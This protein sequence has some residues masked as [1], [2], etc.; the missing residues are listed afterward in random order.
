MSRSSEVTHPRSVEREISIDAPVDVVW[1]ALTDA[2]ELM[3]WFPLNATVTP[4]VG[5]SIMTR[6]DEAH[7]NDDGRIEIWEPEHHLRTVG[8]GG[9]W[10]GIA[11]D[12]YL[13]GKAG[14]TVLRVVSSG[15]GEGEDW[16]DLLNSFGG[17][18]DFELRG[19]RFYLERHRGT[20]RVVA[21]A[22]VP[23]T[24]GHLEAWTRVL[25][26]GGWFGAEGLD[27]VAAGGRCDV[28]VATGEAIEG[29]VQLNQPPHQ[30]SVITDSWN[31]AVLRVLLFGKEVWLWLATYGVATNE[32]RAIQTRWRDSLG[33]LFSKPA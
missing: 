23:Y 26:P 33:R 17:G 31:G 32:V 1:R 22:R 12:Y 5:G 29:I 27:R 14:R 28:R 3:R 24:C 16:D 30:L 15:F 10:V 25:G 18:W 2:R 9:S 6:W 20:D 21:W 8:Q 19:L 7:E 11:T 13:Q 4:G